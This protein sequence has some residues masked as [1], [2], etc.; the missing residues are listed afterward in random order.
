M[1][2]TE[3]QRYDPDVFVPGSP[4]YNEMDDT[5]PRCRSCGSREIEFMII[6]GRRY[7]SCKSCG[8]YSGN[9]AH[10]NP[11]TATPPPKGCTPRIFM[12]LVFLGII[13]GIVFIVKKLF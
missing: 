8:R 5:P 12:T 13:G 11:D 2:S 6:R 4:F 1:A 10:Y 9:P 3:E 7:W